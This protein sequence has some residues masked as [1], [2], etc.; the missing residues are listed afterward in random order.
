MNQQ[1]SIES[2]LLSKLIDNLNAE[3]VLGTIQNIHEAAEWLRYTYLYIRMRKQPQLYGISNESLQIDNTLLQRRL[4][5][6]HSAAIQL[7]KNHLIHYDR[8][9]GNF[10]MTEHGRIASYY[11]CTHETI[12][13]YNKLLKPTLNEIELFRIFSLSSEFRHITVR[14]EEKLELKKIN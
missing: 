8:K 12:S 9:T 7:D 1:L 2:Q 5:L 4:D 10:Q 13:M 6:I 11:Y 14:E 3:I